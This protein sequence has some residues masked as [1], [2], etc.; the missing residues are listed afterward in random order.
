MCEFLDQNGVPLEV[1]D[2]IEYW[3]TERQ[4][5]IAKVVT[6]ESERGQHRAKNDD[7]EWGW[8]TE[9]RKKIFVQPDTK[10]NPT[11]RYSNVVRLTK[12]ANI[13]KVI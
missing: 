9:T 2:E 8:F 11:R 3:G 4:W 1:G 12:S 5:I 13:R 7:G 6:I 10:K